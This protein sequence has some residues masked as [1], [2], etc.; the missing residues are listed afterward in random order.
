MNPAMYRKIIRS[1]LHRIIDIHL[2][3]IHLL[4]RISCYFDGTPIDLRIPHHPKYLKK[5]MLEKQ[6]TRF[7]FAK[8]PQ[9]SI[10]GG[11]NVTTQR[12]PLLE[13]PGIQSEH[14]STHFPEKATDESLASS[15][16]A[17]SRKRRSYDNP[18]NNQSQAANVPVRTTNHL[19]TGKP[20][21]SDKE[22]KTS[23]TSTLKV[24][25]DRS[26]LAQLPALPK[27]SGT[28][29]SLKS[30]ST[31]DR[32]SSLAQPLALAKESGPKPSLQA[33]QHIKSIIVVPPGKTP[34]H[35]TSVE[36]PWLDDVPDFLLNP[37][38][39]L[40]LEEENQDQFTLMEY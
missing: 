5:I 2:D 36:R 35:T 12:P 11:R 24:L 18:A 21:M 31:L 27:E 25:L 34:K 29:P 7:T 28:R 39:P 38:D 14:K 4:D 13:K 30:Y 33:T 10:L 1:N 19:P 23:C 16:P 32:E 40:G 9:P 3:E 17:N 8:L 20:L 37:L 22:N 15:Q 26:S 6:D